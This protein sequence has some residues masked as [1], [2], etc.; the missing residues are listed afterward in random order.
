MIIIRRSTLM[1]KMKMPL[2]FAAAVCAF[3]LS[4]APAMA[5]TEFQQK[6]AKSGNQG[7]GGKQVFKTKA[8]AVECG[9]EVS[10]GGSTEEKSK[11]AFEE[12]EYKKCLAFGFAEA[13]ISPVKYNFHA[14]N[15]ATVTNVVLIKAGGCEVEVREEFPTGKNKEL[16]GITYNNI[17]VDEA[18]EIKAKVTG[19]TYNVV[20]G[21]PLGICGGTGE[22]SNGEY[23]GTAKTEK[24]AGELK[25][26]NGKTIVKQLSYVDL[27]LV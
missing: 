23:E 3:A 27:Q 14:N 19:I 5:F 1:L 6:Q 12:V 16:A 17:G 22:A 26:W 2:L 11:Q 13:V 21:G 24:Y 9:E 20:K 4:A 15:T 25:Q 7:S 18:I 8:G 10:N